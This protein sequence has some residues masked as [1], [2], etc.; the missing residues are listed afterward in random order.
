M[1]RDTTR[2]IRAAGVIWVLAGA[3]WFVGEAI[4]ASA[5]PGY[6]YATNYI[7]DLGIPD[8]GAFQGRAIDSP[9]HAVMNVT[10]VAQGLLFAVAAVLAGLAV[11]GG[12]RRLFLGLAVAHAVGMTLVGIVHG[13]QASVD[14]GIAVLHVIGA[15]L[16]IIAGNVGA[17][18]AGLSARAPRA[19]RV[20]SVLLGA[21]GLVGLVMLEVDSMSSTIDLLPDGVWERSA[22][23]AIIVWEL[24]TGILL[25]ATTIRGRAS[26]RPARAR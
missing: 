6:D 17:I 2:S 10:F 4:T 3:A 16:A 9:L 22:V 18:V 20:A 12:R 24:L 19:Y 1:Q 23:Y 5:F 15:A 8:V 25:L 21:V 7:S 13:S 26:S 11:R 14:S